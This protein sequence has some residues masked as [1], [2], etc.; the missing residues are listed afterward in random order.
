MSFHVG[1]SVVCW[2]GVD[3]LLPTNTEWQLP[4]TVLIKFVS[5]DEHDVLK[6]YTVVNK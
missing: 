3:S 6:T 4:E 1:D 5:P 2:L